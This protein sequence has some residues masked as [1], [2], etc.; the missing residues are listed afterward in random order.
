MNKIN[1]HWHSFLRD[2]WQVKYTVPLLLV[3]VAGSVYGYYWYAGQLT[4]TPKRLWIFV[5]DSPLATTM[6]AFVLLLS[7][8]GYR[9]TFFS[10]VAFTA[11]IKYGLWAVIIISD[12]WAGGG[13]VRFTEAMLW[14][15]HIGMAVQG[16][17]YLNTYLSGRP[18]GA[19][20]AVSGPV[21]AGAAAWML[22]NDFLDY[23]LGIYPYL[24]VPGQKLLAG[25]SAVSLSLLLI[26]TVKA[27]PL[28]KL[29]DNSRS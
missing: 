4:S 28:K 8:F 15:S 20:R 18:R 12:F 24:Y 17:I 11:C 23:Y 7:L 9:N 22:L 13:G 1:H 19:A 3:N 16:A 2:P 25:V 6:F 10:L 5:P 26:L 29:S 14:A 27:A 21:L